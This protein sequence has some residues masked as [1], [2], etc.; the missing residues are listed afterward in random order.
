MDHNME[1]YINLFNK[2]GSA[3]ILKPIDMR[4]IPPKKHLEKLKRD[5]PKFKTY[6][7]IFQWDK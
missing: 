5:L 4:W 7:K 6:Y 1:Y 2:A 3:F